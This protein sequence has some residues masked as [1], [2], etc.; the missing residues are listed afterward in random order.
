MKQDYYT[1][2]AQREVISCV[3]SA[4]QHRPHSMS[5]TSIIKRD[6]TDP[7]VNRNVIMFN[8]VN[9]FTVNML[10]Y[11]FTTFKYSNIKG[12]EWW[13]MPEHIQRPLTK[14]ILRQL[15]QSLR[16][17]CRKTVLVSSTIF[18]FKW[19]IPISINLLVYN[20]HRFTINASMISGLLWP[21]AHGSSVGPATASIQCLETHDHFHDH[22]YA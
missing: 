1:T 10:Y 3:T 12:V 5:I 16:G 6:L 4:C 22:D 15:L 2:N 8:Q 11:V 14:S 18:P 13:V 21:I 17:T 9:R 7:C 20:P 19:R